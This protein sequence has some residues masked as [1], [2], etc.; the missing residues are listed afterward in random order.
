MLPFNNEQTNVRV[1]GSLEPGPGKTI[2]VATYAFRG[3]PYV[4]LDLEFSDPSYSRRQLFLTLP[5][6]QVGELVRLL[7]LSV[8]EL[9]I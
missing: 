2:T 9:G 8:K 1:I 6:V 7:E 3:A 5:A 4:R